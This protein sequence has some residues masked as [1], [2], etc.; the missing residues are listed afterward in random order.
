MLAQGAMAQNGFEPGGGGPQPGPQAGEVYAEPI[1]GS[2]GKQ[3]IPMCVYVDD[4]ATPGGD[5][6]SWAA[7]FD[8]LTDALVAAAQPGS[9]I[10]CIRVGQGTYAPGIEQPGAGRDATFELIDG[11]DILGGYAGVTEPNPDARN[12]SL[13]PTILD[14]DTAQDDLQGVYLLR[15]NDNVYHVV[16]G[17]TSVSNTTLVS[18]LTIRNGHANN[19][20][21][22]DDRFGGGATLDGASPVFL[23][24][25]FED[26]YAEVSGGAI[27]VENVGGPRLSTCTAH[28]NFANQNGGMLGAESAGQISITG[29]TYEYNSASN[30]GGAVYVYFS[31]S[32]S[33]RA[34]MNDNIAGNSGGAVFASNVPLFTTSS[35]PNGY[36]YEAY[37]RNTALGRGGA[38]YLESCEHI[39]FTSNVIEDN[40][41]FS[42]GGAVYIIGAGT[43]YF[44]DASFRRNECTS[45]GGALYAGSGTDVEARAGTFQDNVSESS[46]GAVYLTGGGNSIFQVV[47]FRDNRI[48]ASGFG[49]GAGMYSSGCDL[50]LQQC[51]FI[52]N[53]FDHDSSGDGIGLYFNSGTLDATGCSFDGNSAPYAS[54]DGGG[55]YVF[56][57]ASFTLCSFN[58]NETG[59]FPPDIS[60]SGNGAGLYSGSDLTLDRCSISLNTNWSG[61]AG[62]IYLTGSG[63]VTIVDTSVRDNWVGT[64]STGDHGGGLYNNGVS[65]CTIIDTQFENNIAIAGSGGGMYVDLA[66]NDD[67]EAVN[68]EVR[69]NEAG[70][71]G[72]GVYFDWGSTSTL[73]EDA[74]TNVLIASNSAGNEGGG[75]WSRGLFEA[76]S[77]TFADNDAAFGG[78][79]WTET[80]N[81]TLN[82]SIIYFNAPSQLATNSGSVNPILR[83]VTISTGGNA[84]DSNILTGDPQFEDR[85]GDDDTLGT[86]D[87]RYQLADTSPAID[88]GNDAFLPADARDYD[89]DFNTTE[90]FPADLDRGPRIVGAMTDRGAHEFAD[91]NAN[92]I[93]DAIDI[94]DG[95]ESDCSGNG[96]PDNCEP[97]C[98]GNT[99]ADSCDIFYGI[100]EDCNLNGIPD[101]CELN[102]TTDCDNDGILDECE[103]SVEVVFIIDT[104]GSNANDINDIQQY[105]A[106]GLLTLNTPGFV[107][108][109][110]VLSIPPTTFQGIEGA[111]TDL[112]G[113]DVPGDNGTCP[114]NLFDAGSPD[115]AWGS[116]TSITSFYRS[117]TA[118]IRI[119]IPIS[120]E[121][122]CGGGTSCSFPTLQQADIDAIDNAIAQCLAGDVIA[123]PITGEG[124]SDCVDAHAENLASATGGMA[125]DR[126]NYASYQTLAGDFLPFVQSIIDGAVPCALLV[127]GEPLDPIT[128]PAISALELWSE[129]SP[130]M[131]LNKDG[132][133]DYEDLR[134]YFNSI[135]RAP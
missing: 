4:D 73:L 129:E 134:I 41:A 31:D 26:N 128:L 63:N 48:A 75:L 130:V 12:A 108:D 53:A 45:N 84:N 71:N 123:I 60:V 6:S 16:T 42:Q 15:R 118:G 49:S 23:R 117:W 114:D 124:S 92:N 116:A 107:L 27:W 22:F 21:V 125:Y 86:A 96:I 58:N 76:G 64:F 57:D 68:I 46:G 87:D 85:D 33:V 37:S 11:V 70:T 98:N 65:S 30:D 3:P 81:P 111:V 54:A 131:D 9:T 120:D 99:F 106:D 103:L 79:W 104:S 80:A 97:D 121:N 89:G 55:A 61:D 88:T 77:C 69:S 40:F 78:G 34:Y 50:A 115:E 105:L 18:D 94:A 43:A 56:G 112:Y 7:A 113:A 91:C 62:G 119:V 5:G 32:L 93:D 2:I 17:S 74:M 38:F 83:N 109:P 122:P 35:Y 24:V 72:G 13:Y 90:P 25:T 67:F 100:S 132:L 133:F 82:N 10:N 20:T 47:S 39:G 101:E 8:T 44:D 19:K 110:L 36:D 126:D 127:Q 135:N 102:P 52:N 28:R 14:G 1:G 51:D 29:G 66:S 95:T 59:S